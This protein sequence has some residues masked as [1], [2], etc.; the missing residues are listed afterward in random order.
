MEGGCH[1]MR[2]LDAC[3]GHIAC[4]QLTPPAC[5]PRDATVLS[6]KCC[7]E[8]DRQSFTDWFP[9]TLQP[10]RLSLLTNTLRPRLVQRRETAPRVLR[11]LRTLLSLPAGPPMVPSLL[12][13]LSPLG[14]PAKA[15]LARCSLWPHPRAPLCHRTVLCTVSC[16][17]P[18]PHWDLLQA[19]ATVTLP[20]VPRN[21][22]GP[23]AWQVLSE[24]GP[25]IVFLIEVHH[26]P[27]F[28]PTAPCLT[29]GSRRWVTSLCPMMAL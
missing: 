9:Q 22:P 12:Y 14:P 7:M 4:L 15:G 23:G 24:C 27:A 18:S 3:L 19:E 8:V 25:T 17:S 11:P 13:L 6:P 16:L 26:G 20:C 2:G 1:L 5:L 10:H 28:P 21:Q 29:L